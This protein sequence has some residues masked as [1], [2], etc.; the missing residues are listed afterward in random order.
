MK[1]EQEATYE[2]LVNEI[3]KMRKMNRAFLDA[4]TQLRNAKKEKF[5]N[6]VQQLKNQYKE[7]SM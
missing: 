7:A 4:C 1:T 3:E 5:P 2:D 6:I